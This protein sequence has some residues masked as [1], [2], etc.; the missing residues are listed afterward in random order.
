MIDRFFVGNVSK[1]TTKLSRVE[2]WP[3]TALGGTAGKRWRLRL[4]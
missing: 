1:A 4:R 3:K 2:I